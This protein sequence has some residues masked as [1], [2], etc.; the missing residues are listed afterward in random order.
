MAAYQ[1]RTR[2]AAPFDR[3]WEF[4]SRVEGL[5][6]L[7][8]DWM[9]LRVER[10]RGPDGEVDP[11]VLEAGSEIRLSVRPFGVGS[12]RAWTS[13]IDSRE[14]SDGEAAFRDTMVDGPFARWVHTH[15][16][17]AV[18]GGTVVDDRVAYELPFGEAGRALGRVAAVGFEPMF[19]YR[20]RRT[21]ELLEDAESG[22]RSGGTGET[23]DGDGGGDGT[24]ARP[25]SV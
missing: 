10:V 2:V 24:A 3:V 21:R 17:H 14:E 7:T 19:R 1:R 25:R 18:D 6:A 15:A 22:D 9:R 16:F 5:E 4:Y 23:R 13:H 12:R 8:P 11:A 20:H